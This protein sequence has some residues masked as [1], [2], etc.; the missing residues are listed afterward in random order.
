MFL[1][2]ILICMA[3]KIKINSEDEFKILKKSSNLTVPP[4]QIH[5]NK[6]AYSRLDKHKQKDYNN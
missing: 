4:R 2:A 1:R 5:K 3:I 6:K